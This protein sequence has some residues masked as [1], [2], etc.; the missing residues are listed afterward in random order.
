MKSLNGQASA[1]KPQ[2]SESWTP[3]AEFRWAGPIDPKQ[4]P[5]SL[6]SLPPTEPRQL[7]VVSSSSTAAQSQPFETRRRLCMRTKLPVV[8][9]AYVEASNSR[10]AERFGTL[11]TKDAIVHDEGQDHR[12]VTAIKKWLA[13]TAKKYAFTLTPI[14]LS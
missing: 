2:R 7:P 13:S 5:S 3:L 11:F 4:C 12:G 8:I 9:S 6:H 14:R 10:D 1:P